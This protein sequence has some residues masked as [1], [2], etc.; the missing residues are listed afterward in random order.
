MRAVAPDAIAPRRA[1]PWPRWFAL[2]LATLVC[3]ACALTLCVAVATYAWPR[4][5]GPLALAAFALGGCAWLVRG[6]AFVACALRLR[7]RAPRALAAARWMFLIL[8]FP[9]PGWLLGWSGGAH[10]AFWTAFVLQLGGVAAERWAS[11]AEA[12]LA[13]D[14]VRRAGA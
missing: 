12:R 11:V 14:Q 7:A 2:L 10:A 1:G 9:L 4:Y 5:A 13:E 3:G 6:A 8:F